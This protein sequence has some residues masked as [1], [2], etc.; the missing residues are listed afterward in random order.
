MVNETQ[1]TFASTKQVNILECG[2]VVSNDI[3]MSSI[4]M[5]IELNNRK[6]QRT[7]EKGCVNVSHPND[8]GWI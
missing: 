2:L 6:L 8:D 7:I 1:F 4:K 5:K 3:R